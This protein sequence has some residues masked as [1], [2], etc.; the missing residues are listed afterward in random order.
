MVLLYWYDSK[1]KGG[2]KWKEAINQAINTAKI[3][4]LLINP[5]FMASDFII[6]NELP[7]IL[8]NAKINGTTI[9]PVI[10]RASWFSE[11]KDLSQYQPAKRYPGH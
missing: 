10:L 3:A 1:I 4:I 5:G 8:A 6:S 9:F 2:T 7:P 11:D